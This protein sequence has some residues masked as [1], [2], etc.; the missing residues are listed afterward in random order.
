MFNVLRHLI[1][2]IAAVVGILVM[3]M[4]TPARADLEIQIATSLGGP[5]TTEASAA[6]GGTASTSSALTFGG[7]TFNTLETSSNS[8]GTTSLSKLLGATLDAINNTGT[9]QTVYIKLGDTGFTSPVAPP[10][11][12]VNSHIGGSVVTSNAGNAL[13][14]QSYIDGANGQNSLTGFTTGAQNPAITSGSF[15]NDAFGSITTLSSPYSITELLI[16]TL[17]ANGGEINFSS[18]TTLTPTPE[19][20]TMAIAG[21]GALGMIGYGLRHRKAKGA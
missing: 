8:P 6:S 4:A 21:L 10:P 7:I 15:S 12:G 17:G 20:S 16:L 2:P 5:Y 13:T 9:A 3:G 1:S 18:N 14:F 19:P 11:V